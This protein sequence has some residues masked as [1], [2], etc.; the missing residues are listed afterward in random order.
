V[1]WLSLFLDAFEDVPVRILSVAAIIA[2]TAG[3]LEQFLLTK[4]QGEA[5]NSWIEGVAILMAVLIVATVTA[6]NDYLK[7]Q[8]FRALKQ[9]TV[10]RKVCCLFVV[11]G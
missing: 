8:Q 10:D 6:T 4:E 5:H 11:C 7:D 3:L 9:T 1:T 2:L